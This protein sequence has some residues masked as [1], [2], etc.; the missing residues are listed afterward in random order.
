MLR[1]KLIEINNGP[2][3]KSRYRK[4]QQA[5]RD[6]AVGSL[7]MVR[8]EDDTYATG[9]AVALQATAFKQGS[10]VELDVEERVYLAEVPGTIGLWRLTRGLFQYWTKPAAQTGNQPTQDQMP[11]AEPEHPW[12]TWANQLS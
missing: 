11:Q 9:T 1:V 12:L 4:A 8:L 5:L 3:D 10:T 2:K 7:L 6:L